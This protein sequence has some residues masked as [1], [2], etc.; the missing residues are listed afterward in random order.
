MTQGLQEE[1]MGE[2]KAWGEDR[3]WS[4]Q[5]HPLATAAVSVDRIHEASVVS[6]RAG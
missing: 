2:G 3:V 4:W 6:D 5:D 1:Y